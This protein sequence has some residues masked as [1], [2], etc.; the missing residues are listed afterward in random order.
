MEK[1]TEFICNNTCHFYNIL[2]FSWIS[3]FLF[4]SNDNY[5][6]KFLLLYHCHESVPELHP[7]HSV[8]QTRIARM[9]DS[10]MAKSKVEADLINCLRWAVPLYSKQ[11]N[12]VKLYI[13]KM[14]QQVIQKMKLSVRKWNQIVYMA[15]NKVNG[16][17]TPTNT[18]I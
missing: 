16:H 1:P 3:D 17:F 13:C 9:S 4:K 10:Q 11:S 18:K 5:F 2:Y 14:P 15:W 12:L 7:P 6:I 8:H